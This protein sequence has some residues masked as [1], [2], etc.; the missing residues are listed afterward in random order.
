MNPWLT[1]VKKVQSKHPNKSY[2]DVLV[3]ASKSY[4]KKMKG[5]SGPIVLNTNNVHWHSLLNQLESQLGM[6]LTPYYENILYYPRYIQLKNSTKQ[7]SD[8]PTD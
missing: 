1:H 6:P 4:K 3:L 2:K 7:H 5:G 8:K